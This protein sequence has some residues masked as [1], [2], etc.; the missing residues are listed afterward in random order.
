MSAYFFVY[1]SLLF[2]LDFMRDCG[3]IKHDVDCTCLTKNKIIGKVSFAKIFLQIWDLST[4]VTQQMNQS[5]FEKR[6]LTCK[7]FILL[8]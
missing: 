8:N 7:L 5:K 1:V 2:W 6:S 4:L 3:R